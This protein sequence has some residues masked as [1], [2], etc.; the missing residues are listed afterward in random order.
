MRETDETFQ[1]FLSICR[2]NLI[3]CFLEII[4]LINYYNFNFLIY[5]QVGK[6]QKWMFW[7]HWKKS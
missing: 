2:P 5:G 4:F 3:N 1:Y 6:G 7:N